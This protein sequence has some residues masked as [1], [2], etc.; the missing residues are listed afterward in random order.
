MVIF[1]I[2]SFYRVLACISQFCLME[3]V[4]F[5]ITDGDMCS[6]CVYTR[7][8]TMNTEKLTGFPIYIVAKN[9]YIHYYNSLGG[10]YLHY[11]CQ[12]PSAE[13]TRRVFSHQ[14]STMV[15]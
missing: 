15:I 12:N 1:I 5:V 2:A 4:N 7:S 6:G 8:P 13:W 10:A 11:K 3:P 9:T 14:T